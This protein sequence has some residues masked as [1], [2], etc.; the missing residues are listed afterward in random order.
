M[1]RGNINYATYKVHVKEER[2]ELLY[3]EEVWGM[4]DMGRYITLLMG[5]IPRLTDNAEGYGPLG[6]DYLVHVEM[7]TK[8][9]EAFEELK[10]VYKDSVRQ[11]NP[12]YGPDCHKH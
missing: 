12:L 6:K 7:P 9:L 8:V 3:E 1:D 5:E 11:A 2:G 10:K 4:W